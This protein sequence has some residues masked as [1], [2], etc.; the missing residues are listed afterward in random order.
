MFKRVFWDSKAKNWCVFL[1]VCLFLSYHICLTGMCACLILSLV[2]FSKIKFFIYKGFYP[3]HNNSAQQKN[4]TSFCHNITS[5]SVPFPYILVSTPY[6][7]IHLHHF[8]IKSK[9]FFHLHCLIMREVGQF[10]HRFI[11]HLKKLLF[12]QVFTCPFCLDLYWLVRAFLL[13]HWKSKRVPEKHL[14]L[15]YWL[16]QSLWLCWSQQTMKNF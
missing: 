5:V 7:K 4:C 1:F 9:I 10:F 16:C 6:F 14:L 13:V 12:V 15:L 11:G 3:L 8:W 2:H